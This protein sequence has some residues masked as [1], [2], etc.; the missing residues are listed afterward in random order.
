MLS[1]FACFFFFKFKLKK[2]A[3]LLATLL[4]FVKYFIP[5]HDK[6][7]M[8]LAEKLHQMTVWRLLMQ[9]FLMQLNYMVPLNV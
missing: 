5:L 7:C 2:S 8:M 4:I 3:Q 9:T 6:L 1:G